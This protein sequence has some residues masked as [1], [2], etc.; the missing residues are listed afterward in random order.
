M[1]NYVTYQKEIYEKGKVRKIQE[2]YVPHIDTNI[3]RLQNIAR[4]FCHLKPW[5]NVWVHEWQKVDKIIR[6]PTRSETV[7]QQLKR[8]KSK[9]AD[10]EDKKKRRS[11][12][13]R[14]MHQE[15]ENTP[16]CPN[17]R[18]SW[19]EFPPSIGRCSQSSGEGGSGVRRSDFDENRKKRDGVQILTKEQKNQDDPGHERRTKHPKYRERYKKFGSTDVSISKAKLHLQRSLESTATKQKKHAE[20]HLQ[21]ANQ[22]LH[23]FGH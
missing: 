2:F 5:E 14:I 3:L 10:L 6:F 18:I 4:L 19:I 16:H 7:K 11:T 22:L 8:A 17:C 12:T 20:A 13:G 23:S 1:N 15:Y 21:R 9:L